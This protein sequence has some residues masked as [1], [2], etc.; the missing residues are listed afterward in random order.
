M[1]QKALNLTNKPTDSYLLC[2]DWGT[3]TFRLQL[4]DT[5]THVCLGEICADTGV[6][7]TFAAWQVFVPTMT[8]EDFFRAELHRQINRFEMQLATRLAGVPL[9]ISGMASSSIGLAEVPYA[10]L[11][12]AVDGSRASVRWLNRRVDFQHDMLLIS[13]VRSE[14]DVM[15]GEETQLIGLMTLQLPVPASVIG[16]FP[17]THAKHLYIKNRQLVRFDTFMTGELFALLLSHSILRDSTAWPGYPPQN[18]RELQAF[19]N[20]VAQARMHTVPLTQSLFRVRTNQLFGQYSPAENSL[21]LSGLLIGTELSALLDNTDKLL[22]CGGH[23]L[24]P[25]YQLALDQLGL[26]VRTLSV[27][28][29]VVD[30]AASLG[31]VTLFKR[32][33][34]YSNPL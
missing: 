26:S 29:D 21:F 15:R 13:G 28:A 24:A 25:F 32:Q 23:K 2:C 16:I 31:Q 34:I 9:V 1:I 7:D 6:V 5:T 27:D 17:G 30:R 11:P 18:D 22:L 3:S 33:T 12:F 20:G 19:Q 14:H 10:S 4:L 8:R